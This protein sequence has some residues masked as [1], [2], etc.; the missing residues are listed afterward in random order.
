MLAHESFSAGWATDIVKQLKLT[1]AR[2]LEAPY[3]Q[4]PDLTTV[5][6]AHDVVLTWNGT[7]SGVRYRTATGSRPT[8]RAW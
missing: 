1:D 7:T 2:V 6:F 4:L 5:D 3:G 8:G